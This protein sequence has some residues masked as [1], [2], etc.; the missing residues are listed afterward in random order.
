MDGD[1]HAAYY[2]YELCVPEEVGFR[3]MSYTA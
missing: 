2:T 1:V 3:E